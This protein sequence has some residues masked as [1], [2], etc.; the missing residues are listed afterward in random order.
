M[1]IASNDST[2]TSFRILAGVYRKAEEQSA[3]SGG[4]VFLGDIFDTVK[5]P[6]YIDKWMHLDP[7]GNEVIARS[8]AK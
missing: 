8:I 2:K 7:G 6:L 4:F 1:K 5:E 3:S